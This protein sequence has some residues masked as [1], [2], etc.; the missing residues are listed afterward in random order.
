M[1]VSHICLTMKPDDSLVVYKN[2]GR[3]DKETSQILKCPT[4]LREELRKLKNEMSFKEGTEILLALSIASDEMIR[5]VNMF[6]EVFYMDV[7]A[8][9]NKQKRDVF[10]MVVKDACGETFVGNVTVIPSS[11]MWVFLKIYEIFFYELYGAEAISRLRLALTD[12]DRSEYGSFDNLV[13]THKCYKHAIN[14][15]CTF[16]AVV[17]PFHEQVVPLLPAT[18]KGR[19]RK[20]TDVGRLYCTYRSDPECTK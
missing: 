15:L 9:T 18:K 3:P 16:H 12:E 17:K 7:T 14:M 8:N 20:L 5:H 13:A 19:K 1:E 11:Q 10:L 6:P 2:K 4:R